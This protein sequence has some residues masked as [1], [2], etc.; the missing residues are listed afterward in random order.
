MA[1][2]DLIVAA[3][4]QANGRFGSGP[5]FEA[6]L[7]SNYVRHSGES[8]LTRDEFTASVDE[9]L[10][11]FPDL[12]MTIADAVEQGDRVAYRWESAGTHSAPYLGIPATHKHV[13]AR[14]MTISRFSDGRI[15]EDWTSW[16]KA[17]VLDS[18]GIIQLR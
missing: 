5:G 16:D 18:L 14:G 4:S 11:A 15:V 2:T 12:T 13:I 3:W 6:L 10:T 8:T 7:S 17:S 9:L 1:F